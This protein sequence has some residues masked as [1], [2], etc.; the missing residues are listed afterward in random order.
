MA[1]ASKL[2]LTDLAAKAILSRTFERLRPRLVAM[3]GRRID[4]KYVEATL[5]P[6]QVVQAA[7]NCARPRWLALNPKPFDIKAWVYR[8]VLD[9]LGELVRGAR[10]PGQNAGRQ[11]TSQHQSAPN[12]PLAAKLAMSVT[13]T[14]LS[15]TER[16][17]VVRAALEKLDPTDREILALHLRRVEFCSDRSD[18]ATVAKCR[19]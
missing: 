4:R 18:L 11:E 2:F 13:T 10:G 6:E 17:E 7:Y 9:R 19:R 8:Q 5:E 15:Q 16:H 1:K 12:A 14:A 3:V